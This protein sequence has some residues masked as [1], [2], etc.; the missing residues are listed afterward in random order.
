MGN[1][2]AARRGAEP[3]S[4]RGSG[5]P[6]VLGGRVGRLTPERAR[7]SK[8]HGGLKKGLS[9]AAFTIFFFWGGVPYRDLS[10]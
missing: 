9:M 8:S 10:S 2:R 3:G 7:A 6:R 1:Q 4:G 5:R